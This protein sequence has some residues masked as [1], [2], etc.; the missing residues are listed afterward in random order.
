LN[1][2]CDSEVREA[3]LGVIRRGHGQI[4]PNWGHP[5]HRCG[6]L[7]QLSAPLAAVLQ[8]LKYSSRQSETLQ[9]S[10]V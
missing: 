1:A 9:A 4:F 3:V 8:Y 7:F 10:M 6:P 5:K 2:S